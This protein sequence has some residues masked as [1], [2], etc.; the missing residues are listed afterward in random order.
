V[1][2]GCR[3]KFE[4]EGVFYAYRDD[5]ADGADTLR[6]LAAQP[7]CDGK[8]GM[9]GRSYGR[10]VQ[11]QA[12][13]QGDVPLTAIAPPVITGVYFGECHRI[14]GAVQWVRG[15]V[16]PHSLKTCRIRV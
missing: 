13:A 5:G 12:A 1:V 11:W 6:W 7:W 15:K 4:P 9:S 2:Q 14:G 10:L 16:R 3:G 8:L